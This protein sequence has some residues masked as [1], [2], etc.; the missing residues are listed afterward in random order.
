MEI[1]Q[2][3]QENEARFLDE[4]ASLIRIPSISALPL[5]QHKED[6]LACAERWRQ[7]LLEAGADEAMV[8]PSEG[9]PLVYAEKRIDP[10]APTILVYAH[11]DVM[12]AEPLELWNSQPFEPEIRDG[13][14]WARGADD[15]KGQSMI[16]VKAF[17]YMVRE[18]LLRHN[19]KFIFE[20]EEEIG[21]PSLNAF[22]KEHRELLRA[23]VILVSDTSMLGADL[24]SLTT[25]LR[26]LAYW[27]IEVT[28]PNRDLHS[29]HFGGAVANPIN[30]L[31]GLLAKVTD[32]DGRITIP[33]FYDDVEPVPEAERRMIASIPFDEEAYKAAIGV[34]ALK[35]EKGYST[36]ERNSCRPSFDVCGIWG[37]YTGE[38]SKTVLPSK[39]YAKVSCR[40]VPHQNHETISRL[41]TGYIQS[42]APEYVQ[43]K[44]TPMHGGEGYVCPITHPAYVAAEQGFAKA[45]GKQPL[46]VRRGGSI[47]IISDFEQI[48]GIK[49]ILMGF[50][51]ES[52][53]IHSPNE[54]FRL[55]IFRKGIEAVTEFY[56]ALDL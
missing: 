47:P 42:I 52:D 22:L 41:F 24:P 55:D 2:Y 7:L 3:I 36:L 20:G 28:G 50:G 53:A 54:N 33:H 23:D 14:I 25:G 18:G 21:S 12:P 11:Y 34:K 19:V 43:V 27:E 13:R 5:P 29:G 46:A 39:A 15:D 32:A 37:G 1:K 56:K 4:L 51:L 9:N 30:V 8:M 48:L 44:V 38:G 16:Q 40:L 49:T 26:G 6:M 31:C 10:N 17:E 45:F 35:G